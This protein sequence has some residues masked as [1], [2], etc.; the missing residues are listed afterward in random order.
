MTQV[1]VQHFELASLPQ[2]SPGAAKHSIDKLAPQLT[3][4]GFS[5]LPHLPEEE[6][7][8]RGLLTGQHQHGGLLRQV[9]CALGA[10]L[11]PIPQD[12]SPVDG[13]HQGQGGETSRVL[14]RRQDNLE[15]PSVKVAEQ[16]ELETKAPPFTAL[17]KV[18]ARVPPQADPPVT[19][20]RA[21]RHRVAVPQLQ[22]GGS[23]RLGTGGGQPSSA[24]GQQVV[25]P[26]QPVLVGGQLRKGRPLGLRPQPRRLVECGD[27][28]HPLHQ[29]NRQHFGV[30]ELGLGVRR[31]MPRG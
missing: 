11:A 20:G 21:K 4:G 10:A 30:A 5:L 26:R 19:E 8:S 12:D 7:V 23:P 2:A 31:V 24:L 1:V 25:H 29:G 17:A 22:R 18:R 13:L 6:A 15:P 16:R 27:F 9:R 14:P 3:H 28:T